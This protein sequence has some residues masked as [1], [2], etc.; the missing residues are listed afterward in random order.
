[1]IGS[2]HWSANESRTKDLIVANQHTGKN[3]IFC[4]EKVFVS[5]FFSVKLSQKRPKTSQIRKIE[6]IQPCQLTQKYI[7]TI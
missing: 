3:F 7:S 6:K 2:F 1:M 5:K 4:S